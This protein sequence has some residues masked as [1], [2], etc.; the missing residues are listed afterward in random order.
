MIV[1]N[2]MVVIIL[3]FVESQTTNEKAAVKKPVQKG[4]LHLTLVLNNSDNYQDRK[5]R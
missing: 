3:V 1:I 4:K 2:Q 5:Y